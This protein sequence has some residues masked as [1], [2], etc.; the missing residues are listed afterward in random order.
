MAQ[1]VYIEFLDHKSNCLIKYHYKKIY[2]FLA[3]HFFKNFMDNHISYQ[4]LTPSL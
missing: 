4:F 2:S 3:I 1:L